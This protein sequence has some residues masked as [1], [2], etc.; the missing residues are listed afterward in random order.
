MNFNFGLGVSCSSHLI[1]FA[2]FICH[3]ISIINN[4][5]Y[6]FLF[7]LAITPYYACDILRC[8]CLHVAS[9]FCFSLFHG[10]RIFIFI[11]DNQSMSIHLVIFNY[12]CDKM[13]MHLVN[14]VNCDI[15]CGIR[16]DILLMDIFSC[17][18]RIY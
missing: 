10:Q 13:S 4:C 5:T 14:F 6:V 8:A 11:P 15:L 18:R 3:L 17:I 1:S 16:S 12:A 9:E 2:I 7:I